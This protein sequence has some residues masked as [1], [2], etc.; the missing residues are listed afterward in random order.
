MKKLFFIFF[1]L[2][3]FASCTQE[4]II[5]P[6]EDGE[7]VTYTTGY[8]QVALDS[9]DITTRGETWPYDDYF[10]N[11][12]IYHADSKQERWRHNVS[13]AYF[14]ADFLLEQFNIPTVTDLTGSG[15]IASDIYLDGSVEYTAFSL[16]IGN[17]T[18][19]TGAHYFYILA[20]LPPEYMYKLRTYCNSRK[21]EMTKDEFEKLV[22]EGYTIED[23][24]G[25]ELYSSS[26]D[27]K[28]RCI[29]TNITSPLPHIIWPL[30]RLFPEEAPI[31][32]PTV[33][34]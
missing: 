2:V 1:S 14:D 32:P 18:I 33:S 31:R 16:G 5:T 23:L 30:I 3:I 7:D 17:L 28:R 34:E 12:N 13:L 8:I 19:T 4:V 29:M 27:L 10:P 15:G 22:I 26:N 20:N 6:E 24:A 25:V 9:P 21:G 11:G